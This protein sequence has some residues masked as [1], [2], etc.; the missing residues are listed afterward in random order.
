ML[1]C[2]G[3]VCYDCQSQWFSPHTQRCQQCARPHRLALGAICRHCAITLPAYDR[4]IAATDYQAPIDQCV[5]ALKF[6]QQLHLA[7]F[8]A[9]Q[10]TNAFL[11][12]NL[13]PL[14][15]PDVLIATPISHQRLRERG[16]NQ[17]LEIA[18]PLS[19][20]LGIRLQSRLVYRS[21]N[22]TAQTQLGAHAR[23]MNV[24]SAFTLTFDA[25]NWIAGQHIGIVDDVMTTGETLQALAELLKSYGARRVTNLVFA[26]TLLL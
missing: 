16:Y 1:R 2:N 6:H 22:T 9:A 21:R 14:P 18:R 20:M 11:Q 23:Q 13:P 25:E 8:F 19:Q 3:A 15:L 17:A 26:R 5:I 10:I 12:F 24:A 4:T 7:P